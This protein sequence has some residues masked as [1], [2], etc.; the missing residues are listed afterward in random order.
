MPRGFCGS[1]SLG[2]RTKHL[3]QH[4][5]YRREPDVAPRI[6]GEIGGYPEGSVFASRQALAAA[7]VH[8]QFQK[9]IVGGE[10]EGAES[11]VVSGGYADDEDHGDVIIYTGEGGR[12]PRSGN[13]IANQDLRRGNLALARSC[14]LGIPVRV[15][16][17]A[18]GDPSFSPANGYRY[19]G[20]FSV[21]SYWKALGTHGYEIW[22]FRLV[23]EESPQPWGQEEASGPAPRMAGTV[24]RIV[25]NTA[26]AER[27]KRLYDFTCQICGQ[28]L[29]TAAGPYAEGA[30][31][32]P[33][34][35]PHNG[36]DTSGNILCLCPNCHV[37]F[38][39]GGLVIN[40]HL[41]VADHVGVQV[42]SLTVAPPHTLDMSSIGYHHSLFA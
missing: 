11:I 23:A 3:L 41:E 6:F 22:R 13:Q 16:R 2:L 28:R 29:E 1:C 37:R 39:R 34:G 7:G 15:V 27:I 25:R 20:L 18:G 35:T 31:I 17:G 38:E 33:L 40:S 19:D 10:R 32:R 4:A 42:G 5:L 8:R 14:D 26:L 12:D 9:G 30:H 24:Q 36:A 21:E